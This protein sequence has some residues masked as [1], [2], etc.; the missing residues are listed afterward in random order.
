L[1]FAVQVIDCHAEL[2][3]SLRSRN[4]FRSTGH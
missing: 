1:R 2:M 4:A 3:E